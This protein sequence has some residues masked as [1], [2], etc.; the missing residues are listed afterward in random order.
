[1]AWNLPTETSKGGYVTPTSH[2]IR[3]PFGHFLFDF[4]TKLGVKANHLGRQRFGITAR[5]SYYYAKAGALA[6]VLKWRALLP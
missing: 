2:P 6:W 1:L 4:S 3:L 5:L